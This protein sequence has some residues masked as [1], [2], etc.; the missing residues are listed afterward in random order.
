[1][2]ASIDS[3]KHPSNAI[4]AQVAMVYGVIFVCVY[5]VS[6][7]APQ[8]AAAL[9][10][11]SSIAA[12]AVIGWC[13]FALF[14]ALH[15]GLHRRFGRPHREWLSYALTA[16]PVGFDESYRKVHLDHH[17]YFG[18]EA[19]DPDYPNYG[20]FPQSRRA[21]LWRLFLNLCG[22]LALLQ[23]LG[24]HQSVVPQP[25][26]K[27]ADTAS[28]PLVR[29]VAAQLIVL[30]LFSLTVGWM[31]YIWLWLI[32]IATFGKFFSSTRAFCEHASPDNKPTIRTITGS[33]IGEKILGVFCFHYHA[34]HHEYVGIPYNQLQQ[35]HA[36]MR[37]TLY[38]QPED[39]E[40][41]YELYQ[42]G[43]LQLM[44]SWFRGLPF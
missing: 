31:Y 29:L 9:F 16:Y 10:L 38:T 14:N 35:A 23:F 1:M 43:Y 32:P 42:R 13:Q 12:W 33:Y 28:R 4:F 44:W 5:G 2:P 7:I 41:R 6:T 17:K 19:R 37:S 27:S 20:N 18:E 15:E 11:A 24:V 30:S 40:P 8:Q 22:W 26:E 25:G 39:A 3:L 34:E 36:L 21:F